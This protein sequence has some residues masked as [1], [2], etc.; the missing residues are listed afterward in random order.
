MS[1]SVPE[2]HVNFENNIRIE[3]TIPSIFQWEYDKIISCLKK[4]CFLPQEPSSHLR[5]EKQSTAKSA[6]KI[7]AYQSGRESTHGFCVFYVSV[8]ILPGLKSPSSVCQKDRFRGFP[9]HRLVIIP[10]PEYPAIVTVRISH[11]YDLPL[12]RAIPA[13]KNFYA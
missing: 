2:P 12:H 5:K 4:Q 13:M 6:S 10:V 8:D 3:K 9:V 7:P 11:L 1:N